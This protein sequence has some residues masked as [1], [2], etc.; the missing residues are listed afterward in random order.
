VNPPPRTPGRRIEDYD[1]RIRAPRW[2]LI[3]VIFLLL[4]VMPS[5]GMLVGWNVRE[6]VKRTEAT[7]AKVTNID[8]RMRALEQLMPRVQMEVLDS[9]IDTLRYQAYIARRNKD[10][11]FAE[12]LDARLHDA[13]ARRKGFWQP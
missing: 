5:F 9:R 3:T 13:E 7:A 4:G 1:W 11:T 2:V 10:L 8:E 12:D 6:H